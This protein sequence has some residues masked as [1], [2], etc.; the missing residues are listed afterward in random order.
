ML[1]AINNPRTNAI[2]TMLYLIH[3]AK[4][5]N[6]DVPKEALNV[7]TDAL[8]LTGMDGAEH[9]AILASHT[10]LL[11]SCLPDWFEQNEP[12]LF[13]SKAPENLAQLS[14]DMHLKWE[15][16]DGEHIGKV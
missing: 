6:R 4:N 11:H 9:R 3:Y 2:Q 15:A 14:L 12:L 7:L 5:S 8:R 13:G 10:K 16:S 1:D